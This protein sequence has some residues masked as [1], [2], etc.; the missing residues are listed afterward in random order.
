MYLSAVK[1]FITTK[2][3]PESTPE[4]C[5]GTTH[6]GKRRKRVMNVLIAFVITMVVLLVSLIKLKVSP[7]VSLFA[8]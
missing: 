3:L 1:W 6:K 8:C 4:R 2:S 5:F 7:G